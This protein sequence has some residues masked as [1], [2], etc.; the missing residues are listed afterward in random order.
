MAITY[1]LINKTTVG[2]DLP[3]NVTFSNIPQGYN[4]LKILVSAR[5]N[6]GTFSDEAMLTGA[7]TF[8][9]RTLY[10]TSSGP[11]SF[12]TIEHPGNLINAVGIPGASQTSNTF[13]NIEFTIFNYTLSGQKKPILIDSASENNAS[14]EAGIAAIAGYWNS[15]SPITQLGFN[16]RIAA[17]VQNS[18]F[19]L[20]GLR[21]Q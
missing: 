9:M 15:T 17:F 4:H 6:R 2:T 19:H 16:T 14:T 10:Y 7:S 8:S 18:T 21:V 11:G 3:G 12:V 1:T 20:Y 5:S 13:S